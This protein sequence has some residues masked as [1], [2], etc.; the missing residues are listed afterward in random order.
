[1]L[2]RQ[3]DRKVL[4]TNLLNEFLIFFEFVQT[5]EEFLKFIHLF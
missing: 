3:A 1:M 5:L 2:S 4:V